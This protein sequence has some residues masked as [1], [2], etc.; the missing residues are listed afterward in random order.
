MKG[1]EVLELAIPKNGFS[2]KRRSDKY[3]YFYKMNGDGTATLVVNVGDESYSSL[4][5]ASTI[6]LLMKEVTRVY[7]LKNSKGHPYFLVSPKTDTSKKVTLARFL[8]NTDND[9]VVDYK[10]GNTLDNRLENLRV[11]SKST[12]M[13]N[14][15]YNSINKTGFRGVRKTNDKWAAIICVGVFD[16]KEEAYKAYREAYEKLFPDTLIQ[17]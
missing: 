9:M 13:R 12:D 7:V 2:K 3:S 15:K 17:E 8:T 11:V 4:V 14:R 6:Q 1:Y 5:D 16:T 10:N